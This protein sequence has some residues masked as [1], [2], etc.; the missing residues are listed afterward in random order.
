[1]QKKYLTF[2][3]KQCIVSAKSNN[4]KGIIT[5]AN[6]ENRIRCNM[7]LN[8]KNV[9]ITKD[10]IQNTGLTLSSYVDHLVCGA[11]EYIDGDFGQ[12]PLKKIVKKTQVKQIDKIRCN[13]YLDRLSVA[14]VKEAL[15]KNK[16]T[17]SAYIDF[18]VFKTTKRIQSFY[19]SPIENNPISDKGKIYLNIR[20]VHKILGL[21]ESD[22]DSPFYGDELMDTDMKQ[23]MAFDFSENEKVKK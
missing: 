2:I 4:I 17:L 11:A 18:L 14:I 20:E 16:L 7:Y 23:T 5:M 10:F 19:I 21:T 22:P 12:M 9:D 8:K 3:L 1:V 15:K 6:N 13:M